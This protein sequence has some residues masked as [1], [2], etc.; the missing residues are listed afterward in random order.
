MVTTGE[1][2]D[3]VATFGRVTTIM[4]SIFFAFLAI[5]LLIIGI[6]ILRQPKKENEQQA[7]KSLGWFF[8]ASAVFVIIATGVWLY[9][10]WTSTTVATVAGVLGATTVAGQAI[11]NVFE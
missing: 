4:S 3:G 6:V 1:I 11:E 10:V 8:I 5:M 2:T 9:F 7:P